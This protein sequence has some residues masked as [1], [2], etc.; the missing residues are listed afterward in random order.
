MDRLTSMEVF[1][2]VVE[3]GGFA[4]VAA[5]ADITPTMV[6]KHIK[7]LETRLGAR[8]LN[9]TT[10]RQSL[11]EAGHHFYERCK[12]LL[13]DVQA[14]EACVSDFRA[15]PRGVLRVTAPVSFGAHRLAP[16]IPE[17][18]RRYPDINID[19]VLNDRVIDLVDEGFEAAVR[20]GALKDSQLVAR[21]L[22]AYSS[23]L[24]ASPAYLRLNGVPRTPG[25]LR[26]HACL[27]FS[28]SRGAVRWRL[29]DAEQEQAINVMPRLRANNGEALRQAALAGAGIVL[30]PRV[31]I[32]DD[33]E[34]K[35]LV[36]VLPKWAPPSRQA[37]LVYVR[38]RQ[39]TPKLKSFVDFVVARF[40]A[41]PNAI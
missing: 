13:A 15:A 6:A 29:T 4:P 31:L 32:G 26:Q 21:P 8:L 34:N 7:G 3:L 25:D 12:V 1:V 20:I 14:A 10:R 17:F 5:E 11:T 23:L 41:A 16:A 40:G 2:R 9:R 33:V 35:R 24:A 27:G 19:L 39:T 30:Q 18:L 38:D 28:V 36:H 22:G 37:H